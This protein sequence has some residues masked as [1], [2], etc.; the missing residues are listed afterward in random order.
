M[1][2]KVSVVIPTYNRAAMVCDCVASVL[3]TGYPDLEV[4]VVDDCSPDDTGPRIKERFGA[5]ARVRYVRNG[6]NLLLAGARNRGG[7]EATGDHLFFLDDDNLVER[8]VIDELLAAFGRHSDAGVVAPL[9][10]NRRA[11]GGACVWATRADFG[12]WTSLPIC[13]NQGLLPDALPVEPTEYPTTYS[14]NGFMVR[15][16]VYERVGGADQT[17]VMVYEES[18]FGWRVK[19]AGYGV[20]ISAR[21]RTVH[22][23]FLEPGCVSRLRLLGLER[24]ERTYHFARNRIRFARRHFSFFQALSVAFVFA[25]LLAVYYSGIALANRRA[26]IAWAY[27]AGTLAGIFHF[28]PWTHPAIGEGA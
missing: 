28:Y 21:A 1:T 20:Y 24:R 26:D 7:G 19:E 22:L 8:N 15:R 12:R 23:G 18:D 27:V 13:D 16:D 14:Q 4:I 9:I 25:P 6:T 2:P 3:A 5:D 17:L 11:G 10:V